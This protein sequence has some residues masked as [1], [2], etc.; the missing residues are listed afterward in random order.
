MADSKKADKRKQTA[1]ATGM[2]RTIG[3]RL[4]ELRKAAGVSQAAIGAQAFVSTPGWIKIENGQRSPSEKLLGSLV[5]WLVEEKV[6]RPNQQAALLNEL[7]AL[8]YFT[9]K[10]PFLRE[11]A[12]ER[13]SSLATVT[14]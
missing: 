8:K 13:L 2:E 10:N 1:S 3:R 9:A 12:R 4:R 6:I 11:L 14:T 5:A 7:C